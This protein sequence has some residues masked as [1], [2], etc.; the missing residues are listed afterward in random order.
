MGLKNKARQVAS[1]GIHT[2]H[3][4]H[5]EVSCQI[6]R[7]RTAKLNS[8]CAVLHYFDSGSSAS[9]ESRK[10]LWTATKIWTSTKIY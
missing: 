2:S 10:T 4:T 9:I 3:R 6:R 1:S 8:H 7:L 5:E